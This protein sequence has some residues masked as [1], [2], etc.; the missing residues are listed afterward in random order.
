[1]TVMCECVCRSLYECLKLKQSLNVFIIIFEI[2]IYAP[3]VINF[4]SRHCMMVIQ[5]RI[6]RSDLSLTHFVE[7][8]QQ[9]GSD[10]YL[11]HS[12]SADNEDARS[13]SNFI[14]FL[15]SAAR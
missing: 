2:K 11:W 6:A 3:S 10:P 4:W 14:E 7:L 12:C 13:I 15:N 1:M 9:F 5:L 8:Y